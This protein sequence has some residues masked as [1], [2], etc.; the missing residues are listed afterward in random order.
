MRPILGICAPG[1]SAVTADLC[2]VLA[3]D[4]QAAS[5]TTCR[6]LAKAVCAV[7]LAIIYQSDIILI[8]DRVADT[9]ADRRH[10]DARTK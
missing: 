7:T 1:V 3:G 4:V 6:G 9:M 5:V 10:P 8:G 2:R